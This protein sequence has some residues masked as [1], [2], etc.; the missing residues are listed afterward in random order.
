MITFFGDSH[1][2]RLQRSM[3]ESS[4]IDEP[5]YSF[6]PAHGRQWF[7]FALNETANGFNVEAPEVA[8]WPA[9][10][11]DLLPSGPLFFSSLFHTPAFLDKA[12][13]ERY[14][15]WQCSELANGRQVLSTATFEARFETQCKQRFDLLT[16]LKSQGFDVRALEAPKPPQK[17]PALFQM[18]P[19]EIRTIDDVLRGY[20]RKRLDQ[21]GV[22]L[23]DAPASTHEEGFTLPEYSSRAANDSHHGS[24]EFYR[25]QF[26]AAT[27]AVS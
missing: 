12:S 24:D 23:I 11:L 8:N 13:R 5:S 21:I 18:E 15:P 9:M 27:A 25:L 14:C 20:I 10:S 1:I 19:L 16:L 22:P 6:H 17:I 2:R 26:A 7:E 3:L 4:Q